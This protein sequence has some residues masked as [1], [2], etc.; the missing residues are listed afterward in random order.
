MKFFILGKEK[1]SK[2]FSD[3]KEKKDDK[4]S[5]ESIHRS[6]KEMKAI[7]SNKDKTKSQ[8]LVYDKVSI[9]LCW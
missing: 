1:V 2:I 6:M 3:S 8:D 9:V 5:G 7:S 4:F